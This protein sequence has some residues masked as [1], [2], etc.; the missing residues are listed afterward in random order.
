MNGELLR[1]LNLLKIHTT[2]VGWLDTE[3]TQWTAAML[4][5]FVTVEE[6][7]AVVFP[8]PIQLDL[9]VT[10]IVQTGG[11]DQ[12]SFQITQLMV[13]EGLG[14]MSKEGLISFD[15]KTGQVTLLPVFQSL[16]TDFI[17]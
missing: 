16:V 4:V 13:L 6:D 5:R 12:A 9:R 1:R 11:A 7:G 17:R 3:E 8:R 2:W 15:Q 10:S 14:E